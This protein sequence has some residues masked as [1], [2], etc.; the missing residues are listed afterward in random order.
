MSTP[1][2]ISELKGLWEK[3]D[4]DVQ[5]NRYCQLRDTA[6]PALLEAAEALEEIKNMKPSEIA[7]ETFP[8]LVHG[9][10]L[11]L[12]NCQRI[13]RE[14]LSKLRAISTDEVGK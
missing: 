12:S 10:A 3:C 6:L 2:I 1:A 8:G 5:W 11:L 13:A 7:P 4:D 9:P 14:A